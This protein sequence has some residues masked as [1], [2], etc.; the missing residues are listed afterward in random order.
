MTDVSFNGMTMEYR[1]VAFKMDRTLRVEIEQTLP[2]AS[3]QDWLDAY[4]AA[5]KAR[6]GK[7]FM[8]G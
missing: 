8:Q 6:F 3:K 2:D 5:H 1:I 7:D 4:M